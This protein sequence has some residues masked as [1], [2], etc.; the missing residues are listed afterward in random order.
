MSHIQKMIL[1][2]GCS[3]KVQVYRKETIRG[4]RGSTKTENRLVGSPIVS[5]QNTGSHTKVAGL[6]LQDSK[7]GAKVTSVWVMYSEYIDLKEQDLIKRSD[8]FF[9]E[10]NK[11]EPNGKDSL[12]EHMKSYLVRADNQDENL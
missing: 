5:I 9:Y 7:A 8:G 4:M 6:T 2:T 11:L 12:L 3:E 1:R 10:I